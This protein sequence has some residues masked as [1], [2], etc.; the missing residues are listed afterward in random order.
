MTLHII[1]TESLNNGMLVFTYKCD[2]T[3]IACTILSLHDY[4]IGDVDILFT[5]RKPKEFVRVE[6]EE[7]EI[8]LQTRKI[9]CIH[10]KG[11]YSQRPFEVYIDFTRNEL[12]LTSNNVET[13]S[14]F[15]DLI[16]KQ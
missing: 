13:I 1:R 7:C 9:D 4:H 3:S 11:A 10:L 15:R 14:S 5:N 12:K 8:A 2:D 16:L 6:K